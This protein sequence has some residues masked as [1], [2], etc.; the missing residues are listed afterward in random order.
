MPL[1]QRNSIIHPSMVTWPVNKFSFTTLH[2]WYLLLANKALEYFPN[3]INPL[4]ELKEID[5]SFALYEKELAVAVLAIETTSYSP[6][7]NEEEDTL[8]VEDIATYSNYLIDVI[9][10]DFKRICNEFQVIRDELSLL[11]KASHSEWDT[12]FRR[13]YN[14]SWH[15]DEQYYKAAM[16]FCKAKEID[17]YFHLFLRNLPRPI[18]YLADFIY[19]QDD[20]VISFI[21]AE[22]DLDKLGKKKSTACV[23]HMYLPASHGEYYCRDC[24]LKLATSADSFDKYEG[25]D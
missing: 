8:L 24:G 2:V 11:L 4:E 7:L 1:Q 9:E 17:A 25:W 12:T 20:D 13:I 18:D 23:A 16:K 3:A 15:Q 10:L 5:K 22:T 19:E 21:D 6:L 14:D